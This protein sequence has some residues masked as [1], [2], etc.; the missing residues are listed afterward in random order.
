M[1]HQD[2]II[3]GVTR[4]KFN[5]LVYKIKVKPD[6]YTTQEFEILRDAWELGS[7]MDIELTPPQSATPATPTTQAFNQTTGEIL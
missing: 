3:A 4:N 6:D 5:E 1:K 2:I 7:T